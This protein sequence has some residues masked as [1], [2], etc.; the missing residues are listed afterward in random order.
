VR[1]CCS[2]G[3]LA[4]CLVITWGEA[5]GQ[6]DD[7]YLDYR[8]REL[9]SQAR[10]RRSVVDR[11]IQSYETTARERISVRL[12]AGIPERLAYRRETAARI[13]CGGGGAAVLAWDGETVVMRP[14]G[15]LAVGIDGLGPLS[16]RLDLRALGNTDL[17]LLGGGFGAGVSG[18]VGPLPR[19]YLLGTSSLL[20]LTAG[21]SVSAY[22]FAAGAAGDRGPPLF[23]ELRA[24]SM[25][26]DW[27][28]RRGIH[29]QAA[30]SVVTDVR[31]GGGR[32]REP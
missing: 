21:A 23:V 29:R 27:R 20:V 15:L 13:E 1:R 30:A 7:A 16:L 5:A 9:V 2:I 4:L 6:E 25:S 14:A 26:G 22:G 28:S 8:A 17:A 11:R 32:S 19:A 31:F 12:R 3:F 10:E 24:E 18:S